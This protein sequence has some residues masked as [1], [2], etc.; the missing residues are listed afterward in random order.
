M[1]MRIENQ[2]YGISF[3]IFQTTADDLMTF[4]DRI[5][6]KQM[7]LFAGITGSWRDRTNERTGKDYRLRDLIFD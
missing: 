7:A 3:I 1:E 6:S 2:M 5:W 4:I